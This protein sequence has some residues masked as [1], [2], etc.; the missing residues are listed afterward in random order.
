MEDHDK[1]CEFCPACGLSITDGER[2]H[3]LIVSATTREGEPSLWYV[4]CPD[5][6]A[7]PLEWF[8]IVRHRGTKLAKTKEAKP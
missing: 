5:S 6:N 2:G 3:R 1:F 8:E 4:S 7:A